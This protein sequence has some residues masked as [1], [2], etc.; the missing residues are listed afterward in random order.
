MQNPAPFV[1]NAARHRISHDFICA[2]ASRTHQCD[3]FFAGVVVVADVVLTK[4]QRIETQNVGA[5][6][7]RDVS[8]WEYDSAEKRFGSNF[9]VCETTEN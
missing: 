8:V 1:K 4:I 9:G 6:L 3:A 5:L 2:A 7:R